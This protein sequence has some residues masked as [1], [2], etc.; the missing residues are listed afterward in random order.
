M[1]LPGP[2]AHSAHLFPSQAVFTQK[3]KLLPDLLDSR[4]W[5]GFQLDEYLIG[6][7]LGKGCSA[8]VYEATVPVRPRTLE[9]AKGEGLLPG[10]GPDITRPGAKKGGT[11]EAPAFPL[12]IKMMWNISV[13]GGRS[14]AR[15]QP[16]GPGGAL[17]WETQLLHRLVPVPLGF[18]PLS[19]RS[20]NQ[21]VSKQYVHKFPGD[22]QVLIS[23]SGVGPETLPLSKL[24]GDAHAAGP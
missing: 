22:G 4:R 12:A 19:H 20:S 14:S 10:R 23:R 5:Q 15:R 9:V 18:L 11:P 24:P 8:A 13:R 17:P 7:P 2:L 21:R 1:S 6:Q 3:S 16:G